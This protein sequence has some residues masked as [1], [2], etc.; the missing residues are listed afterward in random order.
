MSLISAGFGDKGEIGVAVLDGS[1]NCFACA[2][3]AC[4]FGVSAQSTNFFALSRLRAPLTIDIEP[5]S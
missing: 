2:P 4:A 3:S 1:W 5:I